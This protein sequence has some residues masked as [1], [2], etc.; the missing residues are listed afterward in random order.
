MGLTDT[1]TVVPDTAGSNQPL[2][3]KAALVHSSPLKSTRAVMVAGAVGVAG[4]DQAAPKRGGMDTTTAAAAGGAVTATAPSPGQRIPQLL[5]QRH[6]PPHPHL[7]T[8][9]TRRIALFKQPSRPACQPDGRWH[10]L[11]PSCP[12]RHLRLPQAPPQ[13]LYLA[14]HCLALPRPAAGLSLS[15]QGTRLLPVLQQRSSWPTSLSARTPACSQGRP[16]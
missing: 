13:T 2:N 6:S 4:S 3:S 9:W 14:Q 16:S 12:R 1:T 10:A 5:R 15:R 8:A 11:A 7:L